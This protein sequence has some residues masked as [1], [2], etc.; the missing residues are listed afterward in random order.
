VVTLN[1]LRRVRIDIRRLG[2]TLR[3]TTRGADSKRSSMLTL[4]TRVPMWMRFCGGLRYVWFGYLVWPKILARLLRATVAYGLFHLGAGCSSS[5][6]P[7]RETPDADAMTRLAADAAHP[8]GDRTSPA[9]DAGKAPV[10]PPCPPAPTSRYVP[11]PYVSAVGY[12]GLCSTTEIA[13]FVSE[14]GPGESCTAWQETNVANFVE[15]GAGTPCGNCIFAPLAKNNGAMWV[16]PN[17]FFIP[18][19]AACVQVLDP[20]HATACPASI[21]DYVGCQAVAC[22][23]CPANEYMACVSVADAT[24]CAKSLTSGAAVCSEG[25]ASEA[26]DTCTSG[27]GAAPYEQ[28]ATLIC[29]AMPADG[30]PEAGGD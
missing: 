30:G 19:Y 16:D 12:Q 27:N 14:C 20:A 1:P 2:L 15:G 24:S 7:P 5:T 4:K 18:N 10:P 8:S 13:T 9:A 22:E 3:L 23:Y 28:I 26:Y 21:E 25:S 29:G 6:T 17:G 11:A